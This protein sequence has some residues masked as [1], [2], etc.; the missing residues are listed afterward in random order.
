MTEGRNDRRR[1][2]TPIIAAAAAVVIVVAAVVG[3]LAFRP[4]GEDDSVM[5]I[6]EG[7]RMLIIG[8]SYSEGIGADDPES[9]NWARL[10]ADHYA[11]LGWDTEIDGAGGTGW[12]NGAGGPNTYG[13]RLERAAD[14]DFVPDI[15]VLQGGLNDYETAPPQVGDA[16]AESIE[17]A[18]EQW[19]GVRVVV[20]ASTVPYPLSEEAEPLTSA[21]SAAA[22]GVGAPVIDPF[23]ENW[24]T[25]DTADEYTAGD[26][27]HLTTAGYAYVADR[28]IAD[29][30]PMFRLTPA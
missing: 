4:A 10:A 7:P 14:E 21:I 28:F 22:A 15:L 23:A 8:D 6:P 1:V 9:D 19:P 18:R 30:S 2:S 27:T 25:A 16:V 13:E 17:Q 12:I 29:F 24:M 5:T 3:F 20:F 26:G 11:E